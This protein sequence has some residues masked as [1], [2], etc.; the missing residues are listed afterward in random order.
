MTPL[1]I[2]NVS[3]T[4]LQRYNSEQIDNAMMACFEICSGG[5][6][7]D[8]ENGA[9]GSCS[10]VKKCQGWVPFL[11]HTNEKPAERATGKDK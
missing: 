2:K 7:I 4:V 1:N 5:G 9:C 10:D 6:F 3:H 8:E 11:L